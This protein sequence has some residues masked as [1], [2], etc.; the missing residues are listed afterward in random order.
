M[1]STGKNIHKLHIEE[2]NNQIKTIKNNK[3]LFFNRKKLT[4]KYPS[5]L[6]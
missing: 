5:H 2:S 3:A 4:S 6:N 1:N